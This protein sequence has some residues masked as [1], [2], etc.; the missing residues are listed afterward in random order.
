MKAKEETVKKILEYLEKIKKSYHIP[1]INMSDVLNNEKALRLV[2][3]HENESFLRYDQASVVLI[4]AS[5]TLYANGRWIIG[6]I[7]L[8]MFAV[9]LFVSNVLVKKR[10]IL[11]NALLMKTL[12]KK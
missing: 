1:D 7:F 2:Y 5:L 6:S 4:V 10:N 12:K 9:V 11:F 3:E 8:F